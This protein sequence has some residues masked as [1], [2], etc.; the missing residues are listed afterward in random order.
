ML[1]QIRRMAAFAVRTVD[2]EPKRLA[3][4]GSEERPVESGGAS[5]GEEQLAFI[6]QSDTCFLATHSAGRSSSEGTDSAES[7]SV[8]HRGGGPGFVKV[9]PSP[10]SFYA[11]LSRA[12]AMV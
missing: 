7:C 12:A 3:A 2:L 9:G 4:L 11:A 5:L 1:P 10:L 6:A 8:N